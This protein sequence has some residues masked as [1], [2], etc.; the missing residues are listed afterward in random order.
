MPHGRGRDGRGHG[1]GE[2]QPA[3]TQGAQRRSGHPT[4]SSAAGEIDRYIDN[5]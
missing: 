1:Q 3:P 4:H 5:R 2:P